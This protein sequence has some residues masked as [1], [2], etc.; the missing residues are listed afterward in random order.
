MPRCMRSISENFTARTQRRAVFVLLVGIVLLGAALRLYGLEVQSLWN[1]ELSGWR[2]SSYETLAEVMRYGIPHDHPPGFQIFLYGW[3]WLVGDS[4]TALRIPAALAGT[5]TVPAI[6]WLGRRIYGVRE[7][8]IAAALTAVLWCPI[9]YSQE[10]RANVI[11]LLLAILSTGW[12]LRLVSDRVNGRS[13]SPWV[14]VAYGGTA[15]VASYL[16]YYGLF[17][18]ACQAIAATLVVVIRR[19]RTPWTLWALYAVVGVAYLPWLPKMARSLADGDTWMSPPQW[20]AFGEYLLFIFN[21]SESVV[22]GVV[23]VT[24]VVGAYTVVQMRHAPH[25]WRRLLWSPGTWL[26]LWLLLPFTFIYLLSILRTPVLH[27]RSLIILIPAAYLLLARALVRLPLPAIGRG[28]LVVSLVGWLTWQLVADMAYYQRPRKQ[29]FREAVA[30]VTEHMAAYEDGVLVGY[31]W[32]LEYFDYYFMHSG[33]DE[34]MDLLAG[35]TADVPAVATLLAREHPAYVWFLRAHRHPDEAF[36]AYLQR[37]MALVHHEEFV[38]ADVWLFATDY[39]VG[40]E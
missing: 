27:N 35:T 2:R 16:H 5:L 26:L 40:D 10:A 1:D 23:G 13:W 12:L 22:L 37:T 33:V 15:V 11:L 28:V 21:R 18:V 8:L 17:L 25:P 9:F 29:Q 31:A 38:G 4:A 7:G 19:R 6:Y 36:V 30:Y 20:D 34:R 32:S 3:M 39:G 24:A 14:G